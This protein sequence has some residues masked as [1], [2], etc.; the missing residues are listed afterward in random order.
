MSPTECKTRSQAL[1]FS[2]FIS[3]KCM[4]EPK[5]SRIR[6]FNFVQKEAKHQKAFISLYRM[7]ITMT[8]QEEAELC[9]C[10]L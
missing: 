10:R 4:T 9:V 8:L 6:I 7:N 3:I 1:Y 2:L 5:R